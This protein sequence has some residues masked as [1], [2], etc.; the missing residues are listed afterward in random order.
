MTL[1]RQPFSV[2]FSKF[3]LSVKLETIRGSAQ[4]F[5]IF[6]KCRKI[7]GTLKISRPSDSSQARVSAAGVTTTL[8]SQPS[9]VKVILFEV[10]L[11]FSKFFLSVENKKTVSRTF[12]L[13]IT[14]K[15]FKGKFQIRLETHFDRRNNWEIFRKQLSTGFR[16]LAKLRLRRNLRPSALLA[17]NFGRSQ[18]L[19]PCSRELGFLLI[20]IHS[21]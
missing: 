21:I 6:S 20:V 9:S 3:F 15:N 12:C 16:A 2:I 19:R 18:G 11:I 13:K 7:E 17:L 4:L 8:L 1:L 10:P 5:K 14:Q